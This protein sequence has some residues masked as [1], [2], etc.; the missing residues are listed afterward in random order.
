MRIRAIARAVIGTFTSTLVLVASPGPWS[1]GHGSG[2]LAGCARGRLGALV[3]FSFSVL[4][5]VLKQAAPGANRVAV[6][7]N[8][9][10]AFAHDRHAH[11]RAGRRADHHAGQL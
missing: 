6:I 11:T 2:R 9:E 3:T 7:F 10:T 4:S 8:S 5:R 1:N